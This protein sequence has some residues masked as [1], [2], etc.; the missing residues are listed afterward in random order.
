VFGEA[1]EPPAHN[2]HVGRGEGER[3]FF[4]WFTVT[5]AT[6]IGFEAVVKKLAGMEAVA[7]LARGL[8]VGQKELDTGTVLLRGEDAFVFFELVEAHGLG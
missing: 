8:R 3:E 5:V 6:V 4:R 2:H 1:F 7:V